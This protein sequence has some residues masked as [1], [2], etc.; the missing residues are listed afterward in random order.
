MAQVNVDHVSKLHFSIKGEPLLALMDVTFQVEKNEFFS[1]VGPSG[2]GKTTLLNLLAGFEQP[3]RGELRVGG[4]AIGAPG[5]E[6]AV[7]FQEYALFP[8]YTVSQNIRYGVQRKRLPEAEQSRLVDHY[9]GLVGLRGFESRYPRELSGGMRQRVSIARA[10]AVNPSILLMDEPFA[11]LDIQTREYMQDEL[12]KIWQSEPKTVIF[13][14][15]SIDEAI[16]LSDRVAIM[17]PRP[18]RIDEIKT[19]DFERPRDPTNPEVVRLAAEVKQWL[20]Q[21]VFESKSAMHPA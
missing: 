15:H 5:W 20:R 9:I 8:W 10:L 11:S 12:L 13:V 1:I 21:Q 17:G 18:G 6:R 7:V 19:V 16:K 2:C 14:T 4:K 3:T